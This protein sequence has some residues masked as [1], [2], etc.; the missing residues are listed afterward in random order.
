MRKL[1][2]LS[3]LLP[4]VAAAQRG[5]RFDVSFARSAHA[6]PITGRVYVA[7]SKTSEGT[8]TPI[9]QTGETGVPLFAVAVDNLVAGKAAVIDGQTFGHPVQS[10]RDIPAGDYWVQPFVNVYTKFA[11]ADGHTVWLHM[12][13]WEGQN[14]RRSPGNIYGDPVQDHLRSEVHEADRARRRQG[15]SG[16][17]TP[18]GRRSR[19]AHQDPESAAEQM[20]GTFHLP[21]RHSALAARLRQASRRE[22]SRDL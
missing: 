19:Q 11:G 13:Q 6:E 12:D 17:R 4:C 21:R 5:P 2:V 3:I 10:L 18:R 14:W 1:L 15:H 8:R 9:Q 16:H 22:V 7:I 20:V